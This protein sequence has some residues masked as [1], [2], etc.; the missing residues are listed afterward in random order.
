MLIIPKLYLSSML[1]LIFY[2]HLLKFWMLAIHDVHTLF[3][4]V[5]QISV[6]N[7]FDVL[8]VGGGVQ[9]F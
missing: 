8:N 5:P 6:N 7:F 9:L 4:S 1:V 3:K 2:L